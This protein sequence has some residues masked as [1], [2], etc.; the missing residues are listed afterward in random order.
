MHDNLTTL[1]PYHTE[2]FSEDYEKVILGAILLSP[3]LIHVAS[4]QLNDNDFYLQDHRRTFRVMRELEA[5]GQTITAISVY[6]RLKLRSQDAGRVRSVVAVSDLS[7]GIPHTSELEG[8]ILEL[9]RLRHLRELMALCQRLSSEA[10][11]QNRD[12]FDTAQ[13][14]INRLC[15]SASMASGAADVFVKL[16]R[17]IDGEVMEILKAK[18]ERRVVKI[19]LGWEVLDEALGGG[20]SQSDVMI[21][22]ARS[23]A[24]KSA[25]ALQA[26]FQMATAGYPVAFI[27]GEMRNSENALRIISQGTGLTNLNQTQYLAEFQYEKAAT[28]A[29]SIKHLPIYFEHRISDL[30]SMRA[31]LHSRVARDGVR[32]LIVDYVQLFKLHRLDHRQRVERIAEVSQEVKRIANELDIAVISVAQLNREGKKSLRSTMNDLEGSGQIEND[33]SI[34]MLIDHDEQAKQDD[35]GSWY[36]PVNCRVVKGRNVGTHEIGGRYYGRILRFDISGLQE[37]VFF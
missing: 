35:A 4:A 1:L 7:M 37:G 8:Y 9:R 23:G 12:V 32:V 25:F 24:G 6:E 28:F 29:Q 14:E 30:S 27:A 31:H 10:A 5:D 20:I 21:I 18:V 22:A 17:V 34:I 36:N 33:A 2:P 11:A 3:E 16:D 15:E 26:A 13:L 19:P